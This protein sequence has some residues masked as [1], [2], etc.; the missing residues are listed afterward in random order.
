VGGN[1]QVSQNAVYLFDSMQPQ[2]P[3]DVPEVGLHK[4]EARIFWRIG[5]GIT[6][7]IKAKKTAP[8]QVA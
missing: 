4:G 1:P 5:Q 8:I 6:V 2:V 3:F 7:L